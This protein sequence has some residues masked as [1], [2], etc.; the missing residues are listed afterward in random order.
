MDD[1]GRVP[2]VTVAHDREL[3]ALSAERSV[4]RAVQEVVDQIPCQVAIVDGSALLCMVN[5][6]WR[7]F[8]ETHPGDFRACR[9]GGSLLRWCERCGE[10]Q[11]AV[12][13][14]RLVTEGRAGG[15]W[16]PVGW[17]AGRPAMRVS[18]GLLADGAGAVIACWHLEQ[19]GAAGASRGATAQPDAWEGLV[20]HLWAAR[21]RGEAS[22][23][24][25][26]L[27]SFTSVSARGAGGA[28]ASAVLDRVVAACRPGDRAALV[29]D[30]EIAVSVSDVLGEVHLLGIAERLLEQLDGSLVVGSEVVELAASAGVALVDRLG[31]LTDDG[32]VL[33][34][35]RDL[36]GAHPLHH[37]RSSRP[38]LV[39][40]QQLDRALENEEFFLL[41]QPV[42]RA[43][44]RATVG[45]EALV[46]WLD[47]TR[48]V[49]PP[50]EFVPDA[51]RTGRIFSLGAWVLE[52][53]CR[54]A[55]AL[56]DSYE[57]SV[58]VSARQI[59]SDLARVVFDALDRTQ[60]SP[61]RLV[62]ELTESMIMADPERSISLFGELTRH[63][64]RIAIDD[65]GSGYSSLARLRDL[66][67]N[68]LK[69]DRLFVRGLAS[70]PLDETIVEAV[71]SLA[72]SLGLD[73]VA[74][75]V[76]TDEQ[77]AILHAM[78]CDHL[79]GYLIGHPV[80][81]GELAGVPSA[82]GEP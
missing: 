1:A 5:Q 54:D 34:L 7:D 55:A 10:R 42:V 4:A 45:V 77:A 3:G 71:I 26:A 18:V 64:V 81:I 25:V 19:P 16:D 66:T 32:A 11:L 28:V 78:G 57:V 39:A 75:G 79:Q 29:G 17:G 21:E 44:D 47:P 31:P 51:E 22:R 2:E 27:L 69:I 38:A 33:A 24:G 20:E 15:V 70:S 62:L 14:N 35:L 59:R 73:V 12:V 65:F 58:N 53:A 74:E 49:V 60:L 63:G 82:G 80:P 48:G 36:A 23:T 52:R 72:R 61:S 43:G 41:Y 30:D 68:R 9:V 40:P 76:E 6:Q 13:L 56:P 46:R 50:I 8:A 37:D 67:I